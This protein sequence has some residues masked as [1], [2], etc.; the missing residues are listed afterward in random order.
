MD[1]SEQTL[2]MRQYDERNVNS[3][4]QIR[5]IKEKFKSIL[6]GHLQ[7]VQSTTLSSQ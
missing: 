5:P 6:S 2:T 1:L 3:L 4:S 7:M